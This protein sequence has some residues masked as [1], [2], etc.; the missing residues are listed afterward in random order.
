MAKLDPATLRLLPD[1]SDWGLTLSVLVIPL[2]IQWWS[3]WYPGAEPGGGSYI[4]QRMLAAKDEKN[5]MAATLW[6]NIAHYALRPWP[7]IIVAL[8]SI[9]VFPTLGDIK[10]RCRTCPMTLSATTSPI[11]PC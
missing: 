4:A 7:W 3:V 1:F 11:R 2:T 6:F 8:C 10:P 9:L 5:A